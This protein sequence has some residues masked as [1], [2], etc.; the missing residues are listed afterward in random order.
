MTESHNRASQHTN[1]VRRI[2]LSSAADVAAIEQHEPADLLPSVTIYGCLTA[3]AASEP[4]HPAVIQL[5]EIDDPTPRIIT[6]AEYLSLSERAANLCRAESGMAATVVGVIAPYLSEALVEM[7]GGAIAGRYLAVNPYLEIEHIAAILNAARTTVIVA[8]SAEA[9]Q[10]AWLQV[11]EL[12][13]R[14]P[15]LRRV[16]VIGSETDDFMT[17]LRRCRDGGLNFEPAQTGDEDCAFMHTGGTTAT[18]KL[19][20][21]THL[22]QL[23]QAWLCGTAMGSAEDEVLAHA[24][25]NF[26]LGGAVAMGL[27]GIIFTQTLVTL[28]PLGFRAPAVI[29]GFWDAVRRFGITSITSAPTTAAALLAANGDGPRTLRH[30]TTG[31]GPLPRSV[32]EHFVERY[33]LWLRE[34]WGGTEFQGILSFHFGGD[35]APGLGSCGRVTPFCRVASAILEGARFIRWA[36]PGERGV[37]IASAPTTVPGYVDPKF[38]GD[39]FVTYGVVPM[40]RRQPELSQAWE[41]QM[42]SPRYDPRPIPAEDKL[43]ITLAFTSTEKQG[44]SDIRRN[45]TFA[46]PAAAPGPGGEYI[47]TGH[48]WFCSSA[49]VDVIFVVAQTEKGPGCFLVPRWLPDGTRNPIS[50]ERL[51]SKLG[52]RSN[53]SAELEF[54]GT[55]GWLVGEEGRGIPTVMEFMLHTR[56]GC[57]LIP[58]GLMRQSLSQAMHHASHRVAFQRRLIDHPLMRNVLADLALES[59]AATT[60]MMRVGRAFDESAHDVHARAFGRITV[61][62]AKYWL[63]KRLVPFVHE[64]LETLGGGGYIEES[65]MPRIYREAPLNGIWEG[66]GNVISLDILR[67]FRKDA[68]GGDAYFAELEA[69]RGADRRLDTAIDEVRRLVVDEHL[70]EIRARYL[71]E[72]MAIAMQAAQL[73]RHAPSFVAD[74]FCLTRV[75]GESGRAF[76]S[77]PEGVDMDAIIKRAWPRAA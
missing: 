65:I 16:F 59:E 22:G 24:M 1:A 35:V 8:A 71:A 5:R 11:D 63:N 61:A 55:H 62:V 48:K 34:V 70:P 15:T 3:A 32:A 41:A 64:A 58:A 29:A 6:F 12:R 77:M 67:A 31:G 51:K 49:G 54:E 40:L 74:A 52:N 39:F 69:V 27:R 45:S 56:F 38:D 18:P 7:W 76:G 47:L 72:R 43:G 44:G 36:A 42:L 68:L 9:G 25:P 19:V 17:C 75:A 2:V 14:V 66:P 10:G 37:L 73:V 60:L 30:C 28:T 20:R 33:G 13:R 57:A 26:H 4:D 50:I 46:R 23:T 21:H 53:A